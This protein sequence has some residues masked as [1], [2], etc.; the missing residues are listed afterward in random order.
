MQQL[1]ETPLYDQ[2]CYLA[3]YAVD[4]AGNSG[5][6][7]NIETVTVASPPPPKSC[8]NSCPWNNNNKNY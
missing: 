3:I 5:R 1:V 6:I 4:Q 8:P 7:S 2:T